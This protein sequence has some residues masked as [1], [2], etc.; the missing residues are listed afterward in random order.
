MNTT[1]RQFFQKSL[2]LAGALVAA[3]ALLKTLQAQAEEGRRAAPAAAGAG[4][5]L[6]DAN[7]PMAK[8]LGF[9]LDAKTSPDSKGNKCATCALYAPGN[10]KDGKEAGACQLFKDKV[11]YANS[12][13]KSWSPKAAKKS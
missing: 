6:V 4:P 12:F 1:R 13:C 11:V 2:T 7:D 5:S 3:P 9:V 10:K 8:S